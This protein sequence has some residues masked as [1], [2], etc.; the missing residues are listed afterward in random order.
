MFSVPEGNLSLGVNGC[1]HSWCFQTTE[2]TASVVSASFY[3]LDVKNSKVSSSIDVVYTISLA[4]GSSNVVNFQDRSWPTVPAPES[5]QHYPQSK[6]LG[7][8]L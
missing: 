6:L 8:E 4:A 7:K 3:Y 5:V 2:R 1:V